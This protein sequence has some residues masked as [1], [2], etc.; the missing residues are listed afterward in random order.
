MAT[1]H[2]YLPYMKSGMTT[3]VSDNQLAQQR[4]TIPVVVHYGIKGEEKAASPAKINIAVRGPG[5]VL[6]FQEKMVLRTQP[7]NHIGNFNASFIPFIEF[8]EAD[9]LWRYSSKKTG[10]YWL[11]WLSL[12]VLKNKEGEESGEFELQKRKHP[13]LPPSLQLSNTAILPDLAEAWRWAHIHITDM[14]GGNAEQIKKQIIATPERAVGRLV[15]TR[16]LRSGIKYTAFVIPT[17]Q[18]GVEAGLGQTLRAN[19][20]ALSDLGVGKIIPYYYKWEFRT[21]KRGDFETLVEQLNFASLEGVGLKSIDAQKAGYGLSVQENIKIEGPLK[22][23]DTQYQK[24]GFDKSNN[25]NDTQRKL[26]DLLNKRIGD[27]GTPRLV[28]PV[29]G[30]WYIKSAQQKYTIT[31]AKKWINE[32][33]LDF[34]HRYAASLGAQ[35]VKENQEQLMQA[36]WQQLREVQKVNR[37]LNIGKFG[38]AVSKC[39][40]NRVDK[41]STKALLQ[42]SLPIQ[43]KIPVRIPLN[44]EKSNNNT[45]KPRSINTYNSRPTLRSALRQSTSAG[46]LYQVKAR[47]FMVRKFFKVPLDKNNALIRTTYNSGINEPKISTVNISTQDEAPNN[48]IQE[49]ITI[50]EED[51][52]QGINPIYTIVAPLQKK[53]SDIRTWVAHKQ[54]KPKESLRPLVWHPEFHT[55]MYRYLRDKSQELL[56][57]GVENIPPNTVTTLYTNPRFIQ[58]FMV[59]LNHEFSSELRWREF[60]TDMRGTYFRKFWDTTIYSVDEQEK[61]AFKTSSLAIKLIKTLQQKYPDSNYTIEAIESLFKNPQDNFT[62]EQRDVTQQYE[63]AIEQWLLSREE[64]KDIAP[65][66]KWKEEESLGAG[67]KSNQTVILIRGDVLNKYPNVILYLAEKTEV[68]QNQ[69]KPNFDAKVFPVFEG[70]LPPDIVFLGFPIAEKEA[71]NYFLVFQEPL[72]DLQYGLD[73]LEPQ[74]ENEGNHIEETNV[75]WQHFNIAEDTYLNGKKPKY[76]SKAETKWDNPTYIAKVFTQKSVRVSVPLT[77]FL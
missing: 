56:M 45:P 25:G 8:S 12:I 35:F 27:D 7:L 51:L 68:S 47:K 70:N 14:G 46:N 20:D 55:P 18:L 77:K 15:A 1:Q 60:P 44:T 38:A 10:D 53:V 73:E 75:S 39:L 2:Y 22:S 28:P 52:T 61:E 41:L 6:G 11:P 16:R 59:G 42:F 33:N 31:T 76:N 66:D 34:R 36:A 54:T 23:P 58:S 62:S 69:Y 71:N 26:A 9:F 65:I 48:L 37:R 57:P 50:L 5:D 72:S 63:T 43:D 67:G 32:I 40:Y 21:G 30:E 64:N 74:P 29:Y 3:R 4:L 13:E 17:F 49:H 19:R 24:W